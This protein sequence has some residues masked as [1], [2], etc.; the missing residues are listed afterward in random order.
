[1]LNV[2]VRECV[3]YQV[4]FYLFL[5]FQQINTPCS[6]FSA[7]LLFKV[8]Q[9]HLLVLDIDSLQSLDILS[10]FILFSYYRFQAR[11]LPHNQLHKQNYLSGQK[12]RLTG[13]CKRR[14]SRSIPFTFAKKVV[15]GKKK[16][17]SGLY[18]LKDDYFQTQSIAYFSNRR[19]FVKVM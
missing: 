4:E 6:A 10:D 13:Y 1:M 16:K 18:Q 17:T 3:K 15:K 14:T 2:Q 12:D 11:C 8:P 9:T 7:I 5:L 19:T